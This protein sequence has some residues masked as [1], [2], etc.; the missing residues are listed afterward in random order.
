MR[1][2]GY[3]NEIESSSLPNERKSFMK[4]CLGKEMV[5]LKIA[6]EVELIN[7]HQLVTLK[8]GNPFISRFERNIDKGCWKL[9]VADMEDEI[10]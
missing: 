4:G 1:G 8:D 3:D 10:E 5:V 2:V 6:Y 9:W 7:A